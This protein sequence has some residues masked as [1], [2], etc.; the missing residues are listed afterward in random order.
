LDI[1]SG[2]GEKSAKPAKLPCGAWIS[3]RDGHAVVEHRGGAQ[4][5]VAPNSFVQVND[6][7]GDGLVLYRGKIWIDQPAGAPELKTRTAGARIRTPEGRVVLI[8]T[9]ADESTQAIV[10]RGRSY[11]SNWHVSAREGGERL[12]PIGPGEASTFNLRIKRI[13]PSTPKAVKVTS[14]RVILEDLP[15]NDEDLRDAL[16]SANERSERTFAALLRKPGSR[17]IARAKPTTE[18]ERHHVP[19]ER[20]LSDARAYREWTGRLTGG[21][22]PYTEKI[23]FPAVDVGAEAA[24]TPGSAGNERDDP[25][26]I[27]DVKEQKIID[28]ERERII[29]E[30]KKIQ[31]ENGE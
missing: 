21:S 14:L 11:I 15:I 29:T 3:T 8:Y 25:G 30:L 20:K 2:P 10:I 6:Q 7:E 16:V 26:L 12:I 5:R 9:A 13:V 17:E 1:K 19:A 27:F 28:Q 31:H 18:Y 4:I 22:A 23:L 24:R